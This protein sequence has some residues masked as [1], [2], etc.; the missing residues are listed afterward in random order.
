MAPNLPNWTTSFSASGEAGW[1]YPD[2]KMLPEDL[3]QTALLA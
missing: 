1:V 2:N 3:T